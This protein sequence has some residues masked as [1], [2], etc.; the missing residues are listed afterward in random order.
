LDPREA[1]DIA[2]AV[3]AGLAELHRANIVHRDI[4]PQNVLLSGGHW[5][6]ADFGIAKNR[7]R[8]GGDKTFQQLGT[9]GYAAPEQMYGVEAHPSA[10]VYSLGKLFAFMLTSTP[11]LDGV[12]KE[13]S[14]WKDVIRRMTCEEVDKRLSTEEVQAALA[15]MV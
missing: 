5:K 15:A 12:P 10:D 11:L 3:A 2:M 1:L 4:K 7:D 8:Y 13:L 9:T 6:I 14:A